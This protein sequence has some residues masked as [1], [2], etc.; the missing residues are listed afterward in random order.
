MPII[1]PN[2]SN[3]KFEIAI[4]FSGLIVTETLKNGFLI[5]IDTSEE[6]EFYAAFE[7]IGFIKFSLTHHKL[8]A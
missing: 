6:S 1:P 2:T 3:Q 8:L 4:L 7:Y 5:P